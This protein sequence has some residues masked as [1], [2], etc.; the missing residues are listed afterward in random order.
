MLMRATITAS[1]PTPAKR[2]TVRYNS[3]PPMATHVASEALVD[4]IAAID[5]DVEALGHIN[6]VLAKIH[7][8]AA[9]RIERLRTVVRP[10]L[11]AGSMCADAVANLGS[12]TLTADMCG[13]LPR[14]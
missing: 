14:D 12:V 5:C 2:T 11:V 9:Q 6:A 7:A 8:Q 3:R 1:I 4:A 10:E 13:V